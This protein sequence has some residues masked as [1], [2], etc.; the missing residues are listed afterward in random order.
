[1]SI[2]RSA[3]ATMRC[4]QSVNAF[5]IRRSSALGGNQKFCSSTA[6]AMEH[7]RSWEVVLAVTEAAQAETCRTAKLRAATIHRP[8]SGL[9]ARASIRFSPGSTSRRQKLSRWSARDANASAFVSYSLKKYA[10]RSR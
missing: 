6:G 1:L 9:I 5:S 3:T 10:R 2:V 4:L 7:A 8:D